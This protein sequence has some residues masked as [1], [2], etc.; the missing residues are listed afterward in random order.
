[1]ADK[2][3]RDDDCTPEA[4]VAKSL[5]GYGVLAGPF[6]V[7]ASVI[8]G[9][10]TPGFN[11]ARDSWSVLSLGGAGWVHIVV[12]ILTGLFV[13]AAAVAFS[14]HLAPGEGHRAWVFL[15]I[16]G[17]LLIVAGISLPDATGASFTLH[18]TLHLAAGGLGFIGFSVATFVVAR[19]FFRTSARGWAWSTL[20][21][22]ILLL[23][24]FIGLASGKPTAC[25][26]LLFTVTVILSWTW[27]LLVSLKFYKE[28]D[29]IGRRDAAALKSP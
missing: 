14:R 17:L 9:L 7:L 5:F 19:R 26:V 22:G 18:G 21:A 27:L 25:T 3:R 24:G 2:T 11:F 4:R 23:V 8:Q 15:G 10:L 20:A 12:F 16:Y 1:M 28:A 29:V 6:Y 13:V